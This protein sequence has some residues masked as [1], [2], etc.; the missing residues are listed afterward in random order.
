MI[1]ES[2]FHGIYT[3]MDRQIFDFPI[4]TLLV[5]QLITFK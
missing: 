4:A 2:R 5:S 1:F 3:A